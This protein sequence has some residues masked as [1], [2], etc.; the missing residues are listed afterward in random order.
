MTLYIT[1][2][3]QWFTQDWGFIAHLTR[4]RS[5]KS[6]LEWCSQ[7]GQETNTAVEFYHPLVEWVLVANNVFVQLS[8][9]SIAL[10]FIQWK[11]MRSSVFW[12]DHA[13]FLHRSCHVPRMPRIALEVVGASRLRVDGIWRE[14]GP[15]CYGNQAV[16]D[17]S[18]A[19]TQIL[20]VGWAQATLCRMGGLSGACKGHAG[21]WSSS[22]LPVSDLQL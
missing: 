6:S 8:T 5:E 9:L 16:E 3:L 17:P 20:S 2:E 11:A 18:A 21:T 15:D 12:L 1:Q 4:C 22:E 7:T 10:G 13:T 14:E 19:Q